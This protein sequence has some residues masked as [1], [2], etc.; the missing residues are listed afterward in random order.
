MSLT[1]ALI[2]A[3]EPVSALDVSIQAQ[4]VDLLLDLQERQ[5][6]T[7]L[8]ISHDMAIVERVAH[9]IAVMK[10]GRVVE[11]GP[12]RAVLE[13]PQHPYTRQLLEAV[14]I[15]DPSCRAERRQ[16]VV[17]HSMKSP[18]HPLGTAPCAPNYVE[19][20]P[21]HLVEQTADV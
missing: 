5:G 14:P 7:Y 6:V 3:D 11:I 19:A 1:P 8:F 10:Q 2:V 18:V 12:R 15:A 20:G 17:A 21:G 4:V 9:C 13:N 16:R